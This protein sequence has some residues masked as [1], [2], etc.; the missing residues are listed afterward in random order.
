VLPP[1]ERSWRPVTESRSRVELLDGRVVLSGK[2]DLTLGWARGTTAGKVIVDLKSGAFSPS[3]REDLRFYALVETLKLG[4]PPRLLASCYLES[5]QLH[6]E[7]VAEDVLLAALHRVAD[8]VRRM[9]ELLHHDHVPALRPGPACRWCP[10]LPDC[11]VGRS[12]LEGHTSP[13]RDGDETLP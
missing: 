2:V 5:A 12:H 9:V 10:A 8:G 4:T 7:E 13:P 11:T 1:L 3:H 6:P